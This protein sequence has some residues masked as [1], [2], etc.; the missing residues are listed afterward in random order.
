MVLATKWKKYRGKLDKKFKIL[1]I[2]GGGIRGVFPAKYLACVEEELERQGKSG[3]LCDHFDLICGT[4][5]GGIIALGLALGVP[6]SKMLSLYQANAKDIF[7]WYKWVIFARL[8]GRKRLEALLRETFNEHHNGEGDPRIADLKTRVCITGYDLEAPKPKVYKTPHHPEGKYFTDLHR[9]LYQVA[10]STGA[11]PTYFSPYRGTYNPID[12]E[13]VEQI[14][15][16]VD[17]GVFANNPT[18]IGILEAHR[19]LGVKLED[20]EVVSLGTGEDEFSET[21]TRRFWKFRIPRLWGRA[22]W[23]WKTRILSLLMQSASQHIN[24]MCIIMSGGTGA[25]KNSVFPYHRI[26]T[27]L[28]NGLQMALDSTD[29]RK[30]QAL[31]NKAYSQYQDNGTTIIQAITGTPRWGGYSQTD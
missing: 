23:I 24:D 5:T 26:Q 21:D 22:Y 31:V 15:L 13:T 16:T 2:D 27:K 29:G 8:Y 6:A 30:I 20:L 10:L 4:S 3:Q 11:A 28:D 25:D 17:G 1:S 19:G 14:P 7:P 9:H 12:S 18:L